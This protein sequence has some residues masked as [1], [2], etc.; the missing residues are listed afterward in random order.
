MTAREMAE[1]L[2]SNPTF[3]GLDI[4]V[5]VRRNAVEVSQFNQT[6]DGKATKAALEALGFDCGPNFGGWYGEIEQPKPQP[7]QMTDQ[8]LIEIGK[9]D[10]GMQFDPAV[11]AAR[12]RIAGRG[13]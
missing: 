13:K 10:F 8:D 6:P 9:C 12:K 3:K 4:W 2:K 7:R 1:Q 5:D 11:E